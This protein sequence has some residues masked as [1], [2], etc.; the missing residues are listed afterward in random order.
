MRAPSA[1]SA[2]AISSHE[3]DLRWRDEAAL[4]I[5]MAAKGYPGAY[6]KG[7]EIKGLDEAA[8]VN[9]VEI[10]HAGT[11]KRDG[12]IFA[13]GGRVLNVCAVG[14]TV[15]DAQ[16]RA[17]ANADFSE[18]HQFYVS[19]FDE[20]F[21]RRNP[22]S[23]ALDLGCGTGDVTIR[24]AKANPEYTFHAVDGSAAMLRYANE[25]AKEHRG[26]SDR[27][28][29]IEGFI[30]G[31]PIPEENYAVILS[32]NFLHHLHQPQVLWQTIKEYS[33]SGTLVF[34]TD[35]FRPAQ[36][37]EAEA[38]VD[39]YATKEPDILRRDFLNSLFAAFTPQE[40]EDQLRE[41]CLD[42]LRVKTISDRHLMVFGKM[43]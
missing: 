31:A 28:R 35:L 2:S 36:Q 6:E 15:R 42:H 40:V 21:P 3:V 26:V 32:S 10:F 14:K 19:L 16:A 11:V 39:R 30:P 29:Y 9:G 43:S 18:A 13:N 22:K 8:Q 27:I 20:A 1:A 34:V 25:A 5:V 7:T 17:Y 4:T 41:A 38:I 23:I 37:S 33:H 12:R 24:F